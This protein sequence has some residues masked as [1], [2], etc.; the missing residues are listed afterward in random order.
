MYAKLVIIAEGAN[1]VLLE[2]AGLTDLTDPKTMA[3]GVKEVYKFKKRTSRIALC[4]LVMKA[5]HG[6]RWAI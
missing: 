5:W 1:T 3:V 4:Y 6:L 2:E